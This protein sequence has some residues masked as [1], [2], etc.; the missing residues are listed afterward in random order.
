M[1]LLLSVKD[2]YLTETEE[3]KIRVLQVVGSFQT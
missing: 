3:P 1:L 2:S